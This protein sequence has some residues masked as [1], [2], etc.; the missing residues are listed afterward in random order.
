MIVSAVKHTVSIMVWLCV[1]SRGTGG[2]YIVQGTMKQ[3]QYKTVL[4]ADVMPEEDS[5]T[6]RFPYGKRMILMQDGALSK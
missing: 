4:Q 1:F 3:D 5:T 6:K 2:L